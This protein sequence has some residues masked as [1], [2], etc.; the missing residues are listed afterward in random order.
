M[1]KNLNLIIKE[2]DQCI[3]E[4]KEREFNLLEDLNGCRQR[5]WMLEARIAE[6][7]K[8][9]ESLEG[10]KK[11]L[12]QENVELLLQMK[13]ILKEANKDGIQ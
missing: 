2:K 6:L 3:E 4:L 13:T 12:L 11:A 7:E 8:E 5:G 9:V 1:A 10:D